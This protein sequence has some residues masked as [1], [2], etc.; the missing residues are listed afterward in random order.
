MFDD[1]LNLVKEHLGEHPDVA[2]A[3]NGAQ[4]D[5]VH[6]A[7]ANHINDALNN[8]QAAATTETT[9]PSAQPSESSS[10]G[11]FQNIIG[12]VES[13]VAGGGVATSAITGSLASM[14]TSKFG[15]PPSV[16]G[17]ISGA[18]PGLL[19]KIASKQQASS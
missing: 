4:A 10:G 8:P 15:L 18:L 3:L 17:A 11:F 7:I 9:T 6:N 16:T 2:P 5:E 14:L 13:A 19:Q 1:I 12:K